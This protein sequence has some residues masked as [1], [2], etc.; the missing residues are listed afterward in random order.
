MRNQNNKKNIKRMGG[1]SVRSL[2]R[3]RWKDKDRNKR[4]T[5]KC[6]KKN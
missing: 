3:E 4:K 5:H 2:H 6:Y 1:E